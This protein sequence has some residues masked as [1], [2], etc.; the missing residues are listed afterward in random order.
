[1]IRC[2]AKV[3][4]WAFL[5][6]LVVGEGVL[7]VRRGAPPE[8]E[9]LFLPEARY[10]YAESSS[11]FFRRNG[12][13]WTTARPRALTA[14]FPVA[15]SAEELRIFVVGE[16]VARRLG[17]ETVRE[18][19]QRA[20]PNKKVRAVNAA[21][22]TYASAQWSGV[23]AE[24]AA[25]A[26]DFVVLM[27]GNNEG[28]RPDRLWYPLYRLNLVLRRS[29][30]WR[31]A[32]DALPR[33]KPDP[34]A[35]ERRFE[36]RLRAAVRA[37][38][39][40]SAGVVLCT[41]P[42]NRAWPPAAAGDPPDQ[43]TPERNEAVRRVAREEGAALA[44]LDALFARRA[45][46]GGPGWEA[47]GDAVH[48]RP[49]LHALIARAVARAAAGGSAL[50][51][52]LVAAPPAPVWKAGP[53][54]DAVAWS[55]FSEALQADLRAPGARDERALALLTVVARADPRTLIRL[56][57]DPAELARAYAAGEWTRVLAPLVTA[58]AAALRAHADEA[59]RRAGRTP[60]G[61]LL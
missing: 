39:S 47:F 11:P 46:R 30:L 18:A 1:M 37:A 33:P 53:E 57:D 32:Q 25:R 54:L 35:Q 61:K 60:A 19:F 49:A 59:L 15:K 52:D 24:A 5:A 8:T 16:S 41:L 17:D 9:R 43:T 51:A 55:G 34:A 26:P 50:D 36:S 58:R 28:M 10:L 7:Q 13:S 2:P 21:M 22:G 23:A 20:F 12:D 40:R 56:R 48:P 38:R 31:L 3:P 4:F 14:T 44:D 29:W 27:A 6:L 42:V 45:P